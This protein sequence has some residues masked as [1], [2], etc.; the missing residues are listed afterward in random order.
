MQYYIIMHIYFTQTKLICFYFMPFTEAIPLLVKVISAPDSR[1]VENLSP[2]E[3]AISAVTKICKHQPTAVNVDEL[4]PHWL[5]WLPVWDDA[6][7]AVHI[8][9]YLCDLIEGY[10]NTKL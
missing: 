1:S 4:L 7:E 6:D 5:G 10:V 3:N 2:T 9:N 8:Y